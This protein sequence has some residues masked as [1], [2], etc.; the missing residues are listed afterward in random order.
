[1]PYK[2]KEDKNKRMK[3]YYIE[4]KD[5]INSKAKK[6]YQNNRERIIEQSK[7]YYNNNAEKTKERIKEW[8]RNNP[9]KKRRY[10]NKYFKTEKGK[11]CRQRVN[12]TR[13]TQ[14]KKIINTLNLEEWID[15][16]KQYKF[17]CA[18]CGKEFNLFDRPTRDHIIPISRGGDNIKENIVPA[19]Q[20]CN[21]KKKNNII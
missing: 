14:E 6:Y 21:S 19:C 18:Y 20:S 13:R 12:I 15:I 9:K 11:A 2:D 7:K 16:L 3:Q 4:N 8:N 10:N 17:R 5:W 1:M